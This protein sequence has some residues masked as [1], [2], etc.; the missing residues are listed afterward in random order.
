[1]LYSFIIDNQRRVRVGEASL[2]Y[3]RSL[4]CRGW[5]SLHAFLLCCCCCLFY[6]VTAMHMQLPPALIQRLRMFTRQLWLP[7]FLCAGFPS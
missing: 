1:V 5:V 4:G 3:M 2:A 6:Y 7:C